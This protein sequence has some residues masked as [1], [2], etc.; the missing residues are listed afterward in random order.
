MVKKKHTQSQSDKTFVT[1]SSFSTPIFFQVARHSKALKCTA[2][3]QG[4]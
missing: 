4:T 2:H 1:A 3:S